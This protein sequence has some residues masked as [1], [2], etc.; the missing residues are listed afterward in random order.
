[1]F[2]VVLASTLMQ[3]IFTTW[4]V[5]FDLVGFFDTGVQKPFLFHGTFIL[6]V[7]TL[8]FAAFMLAWSMSTAGPRRTRTDPATAFAQQPPGAASAGSCVRRS[9]TLREE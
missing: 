9:N 1:M 2:H 3:A 8:L 4:L 6:D 7:W 5:Q